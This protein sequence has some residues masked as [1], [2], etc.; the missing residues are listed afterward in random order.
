MP[1]VGAYSTLDHPL[2]LVFEFM[3]RGNL[4]EYLRAEP[5]ANKLQL[6]PPSILIEISS[7][8]RRNLDPFLCQVVGIARGLHHMRDLGVVHGNLESV[9]CRGRPFFVITRSHPRSSRPMSLW[10]PMALL[11]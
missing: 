10:I 4:A 2:S 7:T 3:E 5:N 8:H 9:S 1:F 11:V 6:V